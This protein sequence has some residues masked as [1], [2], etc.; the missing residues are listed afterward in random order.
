VHRG[1]V[2]EGRLPGILSSDA[3]GY[4]VQAEI[5]AAARALERGDKAPLLRLA[6]ENDQPGVFG[7]S[8]DPTL[9]SIGHNVARF[10]TDFTFPWDKQSSPADRRAQFDDARA[11]LDP[12][13]FAPFL[14]DAWS[15]PA[16]QGGF[17][18]DPCIG[19]PAPPHHP[20]E[21]V[22][23]G[24]VVPDVPALVITGDLDLSRRSSPPRSPRCSPAAAS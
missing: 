10:C 24:T 17:P 1:P 4:L 7:E 8:E 20:E 18:P 11:A 14:I 22:A 23:A 15:R 16:G 21:P 5:T 9:F 2:G 3:G 12:D 13:R 19:W 6:A